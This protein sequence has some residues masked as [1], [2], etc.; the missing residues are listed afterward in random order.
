MKLAICLSGYIRTLT[1]AFPASLD[2]IRK[3]NPD[4]ELDIFASFWSGGNNRTR[5][6]NDP[7]HFMSEN[8][9]NIDADVTQEWLSQF[10][11]ARSES[12]L[13]ND[14]PGLMNEGRL[15]F[16]DNNKHLLS[17]YFVVERSMKLSA[18]CND[19]YF[20]RLRP[21][22]IIH[23]FPNLK[24]MTCDI[25][26]NKYAWYMHDAVNGHENE[27]VWLVKGRDVFVES[28]SLY[29]NIIKKGCKVE[30]PSHG[31]AVAGR[32]FENI[33]CKKERYNF[34]YRVVR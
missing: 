28:C 12:I 17:Q 20:L 5:H 2:A 9:V 21:D 14:M 24:D 4:I 23:S 34:E 27:M 7:W 29:S 26:T 10:G 19:E 31:E 18:G 33:A 15:Y 16:G 30:E 32:Y 11:Q 22:I 25:I 1:H 13:I 3:S 6:I 8:A